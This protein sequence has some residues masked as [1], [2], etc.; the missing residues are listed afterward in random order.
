V[1]HIVSHP[2]THHF[3]THPLISFVSTSSSPSQRSQIASID[4]FT[5]TSGLANR[6]DPALD[7][8]GQLKTCDLSRCCHIHCCRCCHIHCCH[9]PLLS[10]PLLSHPLLL[11]AV[12]VTILLWILDGRL[13]TLVQHRTSTLWALFRAFGSK[14]GS[15][16]L[17]CFLWNR[18]QT[19]QQLINCFN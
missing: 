7:P 10:Q 12:V 9:H 14:S 18:D 6:K 16:I 11:P 2:P 3:V 19:V 4:S 15:E 5:Q 8:S 17:F 13:D 1:S